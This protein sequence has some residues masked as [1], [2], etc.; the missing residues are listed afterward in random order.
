MLNKLK[1][2]LYY[3]VMTK[4]LIILTIGL[5]YLPF[6]ASAADFKQLVL[7]SPNVKLAESRVYKN[8]TVFQALE[9]LKKALEMHGQ[10]I[11]TYEPEL[12]ILTSSRN[13][14]SGP[15]ATGPEKLVNSLISPRQLGIFGKKT[16]DPILEERATFIVTTTG[17]NDENV[18]VQ[19]R[20]LYLNWG[21]EE[22]V[23]AS[24][25]LNEGLEYEMIYYILENELDRLQ[26]VQ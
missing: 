18:L 13:K 4:R 8:V 7:K 1:L 11:E 24:A 3:R 15:A 9:G 10:V 14:R 23:T 26:E 5:V 6:F 19:G 21:S 20:L 16:P 25:V 2:F 12:G 17:E 22:T